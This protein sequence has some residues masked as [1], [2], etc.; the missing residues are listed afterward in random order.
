M[1]DLS[2]E[3]EACRRLMEVDVQLQRAEGETDRKLQQKESLTS[4]SSFVMCG[5]DSWVFYLPQCVCVCCPDWDET[6]ANKTKGCW[7]V[8]FSCLVRTK[9]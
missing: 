3:G 1:N 9:V 8:Q 7:E 2:A 5:T 4:S 6:K